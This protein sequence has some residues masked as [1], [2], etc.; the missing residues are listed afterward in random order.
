[1]PEGWGSWDAELWEEGFAERLELPVVVTWQDWDD[2]LDVV[3][4]CILAGFDWLTGVLKLFTTFSSA[5]DDER[6]VWV[7]VESGDALA[8]GTLW[9]TDVVEVEVSDTW[10]LVEGVTDVWPAGTWNGRCVTKK[11]IIHKIKRKAILSIFLYSC[12]PTLNCR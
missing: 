10:A 12:L 5:A 9:V 7:A 4:V 6:T 2:I 3:R 1:M 8:V 11:V